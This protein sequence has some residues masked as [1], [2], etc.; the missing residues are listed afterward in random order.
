VCSSDL[1]DD[2]IEGDYA[3]ASVRFSGTMREA[4][5]AAPEAFDEVWNVRKDLRSRDPA[6]LIAGI[7]QFPLAA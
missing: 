2:A 7:Q 6:W 1:L 5:D 3:W 4:P